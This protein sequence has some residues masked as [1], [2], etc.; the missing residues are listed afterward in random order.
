MPVAER[1]ESRVMGRKVV[2][3]ILVFVAAGLVFYFSPMLLLALSLLLDDGVP[4]R[5]L[6]V[7][8]MLGMVLAPF[9]VVLWGLYLIWFRKTDR[10]R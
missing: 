10:K 7:S 5:I 6:F 4:M 1:E 9:Q 8:A 2:L 3:S